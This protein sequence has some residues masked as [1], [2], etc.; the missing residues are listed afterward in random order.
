MR[1]IVLRNLLISMSLG[2][3]TIQIHIPGCKSLKEKR[4]RLK[5]L[6]IR[7]HREFNVSVAE[8]DQM[9]IWQSTVIACALISNNNGYTQRKLQKVIDWIENY[10]PDVDI[11]DDQ[12]ELI[13][14]DFGG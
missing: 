5:P 9:D 6:L 11:I 7:L 1:T 10:W 13:K 12:M 14:F 2:L 8:V 4:R 3:L